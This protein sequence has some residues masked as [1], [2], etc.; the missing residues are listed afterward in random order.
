MLARQASP[1]LHACAPSPR[2]KY[3]HGS[4][5]DF[6]NPFDRGCHANCVEACNPRTASPAPYVLRPSGS[7]MPGSSEG[8]A[9]ALLKMEGGGEP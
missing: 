8:E 5:G 6:H 4:D 7:G 9:L 1:T 2:Y 3:L